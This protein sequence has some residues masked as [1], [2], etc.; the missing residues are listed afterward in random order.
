V[1]GFFSLYTHSDACCLPATAVATPGDPSQVDPPSATV[2]PSTT[3][4]FPPAL[5][6]TRK[7]PPVVAFAVPL[8]VVAAILLVAGGLSLHHRKMLRKEQ[9]C[10][11]EKVFLSHKASLTSFKSSSTQSDVEQALDVLSRNGLSYGS[12][13]GD[14][15]T[16]YRRTPRES[17]RQ[18]FPAYASSLCRSTRTTSYNGKRTRPLR[19]N[20]PSTGSRNSARSH[21]TAPS[22]RPLVRGHSNGSETSIDSIILDYFRP[23]SPSIPQAL[24]TRREVEKSA[25]VH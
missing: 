22:A 3:L 6:A 17:T 13:N 15:Y 20:R 25:R 11:K 14:H 2:N 5:S 10:E 8:S 16:E 1:S 23:P 9:A 21:F 7:S 19:S 18:P 12:E 4:P 24:H